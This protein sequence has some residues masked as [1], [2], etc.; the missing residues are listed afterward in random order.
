MLTTRSSRRLLRAAALALTMAATG[1]MQTAT[2]APTP[3]PPSGSVTCPVDLPICV[4]V[5]ENP[6]STG[7]GTRQVSSRR[8]SSECRMPAGHPEAGNV[9]DCY[10]PSLGWFNGSSGCY[11]A[12]VSPPPGPQDP[13]W[14]GNYP[15]G[16]IYQMTCP[17]VVGTGGGWVWRATPPAGF[18]A[19]VTPVQLAERAVE[20]LGL[21]GPQI[22][23]APPPGTTGRGRSAGLAVD[24]GNADDAGGRRRRRVCRGVVG[25][26]DRPSAADRLVDG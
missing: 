1:A 17:G 18:G 5:A 19:G 8:S 15:N 14:E 2:A 3:P 26:G 10:E 16:S 22:G 25:D 9:V 20:L 13:A 23:I 24:S 12:A 21:K 6:G 7:T 4:I 11:F